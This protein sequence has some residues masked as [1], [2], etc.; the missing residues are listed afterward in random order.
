MK[1]K[2]KAGNVLKQYYQARE[3]KIIQ[4]TP[5]KEIKFNEELVYRIA[6]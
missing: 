2:A 1:N 5:L 6:N 4:N 3:K